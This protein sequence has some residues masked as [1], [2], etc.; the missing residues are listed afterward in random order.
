MTWSAP[1]DR[2][3]SVLAVRHTPV[4]SAAA[5][6]AICTAKVPTPPDAPM[7]STRWPACTWPRSRTACRAVGAE[8]GA[9]AAWAAG[10]VTRAADLLREPLANVGCDP[11]AVRI[12]T[13]L[14]EP[15]AGD[16]DLNELASQLPGCHAIPWPGSC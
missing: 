6:L 9:A 10:H 15:A 2:T 3:M 14:R 16:D 8:T 1:R 11:L 5:A 13:G 4:T 12:T 7:T